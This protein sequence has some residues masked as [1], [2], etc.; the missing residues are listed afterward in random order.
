MAYRDRDR[1][2]EFRGGAEERGERSQYGRSDYEERSRGP[3]QFGREYETGGRSQG[4]QSGRGYFGESYGSQ[5]QSDRFR[6][7][8]SQG[9]GSQG[10][11]PQGSETPG[12]FGSSGASPEFGRGGYGRGFEGMDRESGWGGFPTGGGY[13]QTGFRE[14][15][16]SQFGSFPTSGYS[17]GQY[18]STR[19]RGRF[20]G[21]GPKNYTRSDDRIREDVSD[22]LEQHGEIDATEIEVRVETAEVILEGTVPDRRTKR[23]A[24]DVVEDTP[25]VK[26]VHN[27]LR[28]QGNGDESDFNRSQ[29]A[30]GSQSTSG[31]QR[32]QSTTGSAGKAPTRS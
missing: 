28:I 4:W 16:S 32:G 25:G 13:G 30:S 24:E 17:E 12:R 9:F 20:T 15:T 3:Q 14:G 1:D 23:L 26:Q 21:R 7:Y 27:R 6:G 18:G 19:T 10:Y 31:S 2:E 8:G 22:R 29:S 11:R 5:P